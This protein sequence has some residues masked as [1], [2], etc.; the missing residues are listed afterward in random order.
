MWSIITTFSR[1]CI[2]IKSR[3]GTFL[4]GRTETWG[5]VGFSSSKHPGGLNGVLQSSA[6]PTVQRS[7]PEQTST[8]RNVVPWEDANPLPPSS[9]LDWLESPRSQL[10]PKSPMPEVPQGPIN[11]TLSSI[12]C[13]KS[14]NCQFLLQ[15]FSVQRARAVL[16][17]NLIFPSFLI[18]RLPNCI[19]SRQRE[20][21][22]N[23]AEH[24]GT[25]IANYF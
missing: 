3:A 14:S 8:C 21:T 12:L 23:I 13:N 4:K 22:N 25:L 15:L 1:E 10:I 17:V 2:K 19:W 24:L 5:Q 9:A 11:T 20:E 18:Y 16:T 7:H 6:F